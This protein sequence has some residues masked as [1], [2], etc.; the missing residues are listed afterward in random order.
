MLQIQRSKPYDFRDP[1]N[2]ALLATR[3][4]RVFC[5]AIEA[6][7]DGKSTTPVPDIGDADKSMNCTET[8]RSD[9]EGA[10]S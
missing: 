9:D 3:V 6:K 4:V 2:R 10:M 8:E 5:K 7:L 1:R